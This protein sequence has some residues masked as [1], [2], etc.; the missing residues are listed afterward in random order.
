MNL[1]I[2]NKII[3][4]ILGY[5]IIYLI[6]SSYF[7]ER[8]DP[9]LLA[10]AYDSSRYVGLKNFFSGSVGKGLLD[11]SNSA[12]H[13]FFTYTLFITILEK[14]NLITHYVEVQYIIF[15][16]SSFLFYKSL[17]NFNFSNMTSLMSVLFIICN[18]F[19]VFWI[20]T[21]NHAGLTISLF[22]ISF[23]F[24][25]KYQYGNIYKILF[26]IFIF[27]LLK[28]DGKV[29]FTSFMLLFYNFYLSNKNKSTVNFVIL[30]S[31]FIL[32]FFYLNKFAIG[33]EFFSASYLQSDIDNF[34]F[35][36][37]ALNDQTMITFN[38]CLITEYNSLK[39]HF[40]AL[41]DNPIYSIKLYS[42][43]LFL[44]LTWI[45]AKLSFKYNFFAFGMMFFLYFGLLINLIKTE[46]TNFKFFLLFSYLITSMIVLPY[47][48]RGDQKFVFYGLIFIIPLSFSGYEILL[49]Y[50][51]NNMLN[52]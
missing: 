52:N 35:I 40:C 26:F 12:W 19:I 15:Y 24:L 30:L 48:V 43:R 7:Y 11:T 32:Y 1:S 50:I 3:L 2:N 38:K 22:M 13:L 36:A 20:H 47:M 39:N 29:F 31:F 42:A 49:K 17:I 5:F 16:I 23:Y 37:P 46:F 51:K 10:T 9:S 21:L 34:A 45:N 18:P 25:S 4:L 8:H 28:V 44:L 27:L 6:T 14:V 33:L 41:I